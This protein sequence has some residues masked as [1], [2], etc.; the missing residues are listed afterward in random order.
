MTRNELEEI[1]RKARG[2]DPS[3]PLPSDEIWDSLDHLAIIAT[4]TQV[5]GA[6][7]D[8]ADLSEDTSINLLAEK[9][10]R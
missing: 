6:V 3:Q 10:C 4:L 5:P 8:G 1:V 2:M 7:P 9:I